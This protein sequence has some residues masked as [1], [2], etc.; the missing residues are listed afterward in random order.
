MSGVRM[1]VV[2]ARDTDLAKL[3]ADMDAAARGTKH[4]EM[5]ETQ[6]R[7]ETYVHALRRYASVWDALTPQDRERVKVGLLPTG[8][9]VITDA[10]RCGAEGELRQ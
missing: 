2:D 3:K 9:P 6:C 8:E 4:S 7:Y 10:V 1:R 5:I